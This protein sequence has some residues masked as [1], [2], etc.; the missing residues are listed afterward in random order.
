MQTELILNIEMI[1][2]NDVKANCQKDILFLREIS[3]QLE[4]VSCLP[5]APL[6]ACY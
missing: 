5:K 1:K 4:H 3:L 2:T 6:S